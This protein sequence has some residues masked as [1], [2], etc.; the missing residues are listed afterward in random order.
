MSNQKR[1]INKGVYQN[2]YLRLQIK[3][4]YNKTEEKDYFDFSKS[5]LDRRAEDCD[6]DCYL[7]LVDALKFHE[8]KYYRENDPLLSDFEYDRL[9]HLL[10]DVETLH[11]QWIRIDSPSQRVG[12][13]LS[14][15]KKEVKHLVPMLSLSNSYNAE[16]LRAFDA[17]VRK[18]CR[19]SDTEKIEYCVE[20]KFDGGSISVVY[21]KDTFVRGATR[22]N[23][24]V[25]EDITANIRVIPSIP[26]Q[27]PFH[28]HNIF[29]AELRGEALMKKEV[30][31]QLNKERAAQGLPLF[32]NP[33]NAATGAL[34]MKDPEEVAKR[35]LDVM[36]FQLGYAVDTRG[37]DRLPSFKTHYECLKYASENGFSVA[38]DIVKTFEDIGGVIQYCKFIEEELREN[39]RYELDGAV[40]KVN[41]IQLQSIA[42]STMHH[43]RWA[44]AY[45]FK[46][47]QATTRL[48]GVEFQVGRTGVITPVGKVSPVPLAGVII[49]SVSLHNED[50]IRD[51]DLL[52]KDMVL[53]ERAG[54]VIPYIVKSLPELRDGRETPILFPEDCPSCHTPL[55]KEDAAWRCPNEKHCPEQIIQ[56]LIHH[57]S[58]EA[59]NIE[60][61]GPSSIRKFYALGW[62]SSYADLYRL[63]YGAIA[64]LEGFGAKSAENIRLSVQKAKSNPI[65]RL[66]Y[67]LG[68]MHFGKKASKLIAERIEYVFDL[69]DWSVEDFENIPDVGPVIGQHVKAWFDDD[70]NISVLREMETLGVNMYQ[71]EADR[72]I[73][74]SEDAPLFGK[75]IL[76]T[77]KLQH[78]TRKE[79]QRMAV[80]AGAKPIS[81]V[82]SKLDILVVGEK[83][84]SKLRKAEALGTVQ[85][86][87]EEAFLEKTKGID[88]N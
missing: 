25:G 48:E 27:V 23:G 60:G 19:L 70:D 45:K 13:D 42:G 71:T 75:T 88:E 57:V 6:K 49:S 7:K 53:I 52:L 44:I 67:S 74:V 80:E 12:S 5:Q 54:D 3:Y 84:G 20:P 61:L 76:F 47:K 14:N 69:Q 63:D 81:A 24:L 41:S 46:A 22:G 65:Y 28:T 18:F 59:M 73:Q 50:F 15:T 32:A 66:L 26:K 9:Y 8:Y 39:Y 16:D 68:I 58:K 56:R 33:R 77:G 82:S 79:A 1:K 11:P 36:I 43:P 10:L 86:W 31:R 4:M 29:R 38:M 51:K 35:R 21:E 85:I 72:P 40:V 30:F 87:T 2:T 55:I 83:A 62:L 17:Q 64:A 37:E 34:S 78:M